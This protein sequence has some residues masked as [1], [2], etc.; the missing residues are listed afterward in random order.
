MT[1]RNAAAEWMHITRL[2]PWGRNPVIHDADDVA[3]LEALIASSVW[4]APIVARAANRRVI[5]GHGRR[6]AALR[7]YERDP[8]WRL[9]DA[10]GPGMVPVR[11]VDVDEATADRLAVADNALT[12]ASPWD[13]AELMAILRDLGDSAHGIGFDAAELDRML[14]DIDPEPP[15]A[16]DDLP[17]VQAEVHSK[18]GEV[19]ALGPHRLVCGSAGDPEVR[20][21]VGWDAVEVVVMDPPY[22]APESLW[23]PLLADPS[24]LFGQAKHIRAVPPELWR[25]ER[26]ID[27]VTAHRSAT[28]QIGHRHAFVA[29]IG[30]IR[31]LPDVPDTFPSVVQVEER[32]DHPHQKPTWLLVEHLTHWTPRWSVVGDPFGGSGT[33]LLAAAQMGRAARVIELE[34]R[35][36]DLIRR[37][38]TRYAREAG[39][40]P[41]PGA[42]D[43]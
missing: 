6:L 8:T 2:V 42:L 4:T 27:K 20:R 21:R 7:A 43:G 10:P 18:P 17:E 5:A 32:P 19:Y 9:A 16:S 38:W 25:F 13:D 40:D 30:S 31:T 37:R 41:G 3:E 22:E 1:R 29:Q 33:T 36:C 23:L 15:A 14:H 12:K 39:I 11:L 34:P 24:V 26:V 35:F 28:V